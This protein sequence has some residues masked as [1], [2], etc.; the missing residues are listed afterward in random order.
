MVEVEYYLYKGKYGIKRIESDE[1]VVKIPD[2]YKLKKVWFIAS[3]VLSN[4]SP[5]THLIL[6]KGIVKIEK[7]A[8]QGC[9]NLQFVSIGKDLTIIDSKA[10]DGC[11]NLE[12]FALKHTKLVTIGA[13]CFENCKKLK[14]VIL[15]ESVTQI[16]AA[17][18]RGCESLSEFKNPSRNSVIT[19]FTFEG[20]H[21]LSSVTIGDGVSVAST[22]FTGSPFGEEVAYA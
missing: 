22:A 8:F 17:A 11:C 12:T 19:D 13:S 18:F 9:S 7:N 15:P 4:D 6:P 5:V 10:F 1:D 3:G 16:G 21:Q 14:K 20:C 2:H